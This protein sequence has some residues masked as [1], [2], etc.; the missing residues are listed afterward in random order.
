MSGVNKNVPGTERGDYLTTKWTMTTKKS[1]CKN[2]QNENSG[3][4]DKND[5][6]RN[7][8]Q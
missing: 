4:N 2:S 3:T 1:E 8:L 5:N 6:F 7:T